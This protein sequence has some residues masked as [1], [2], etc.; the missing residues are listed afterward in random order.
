MPQIARELRRG[1]QSGA[2]RDGY[3]FLRESAGN[4]GFAEW[5]QNGQHKWRERG[6]P[7]AD[8]AFSPASVEAQQT[9]LGF[10]L[11]LLA[12]LLEHQHAQLAK[13]CVEREAGVGVYALPCMGLPPDV[14]SAMEALALTPERVATF[15]EPFYWDLGIRR[16]GSGSASYLHQL[17]QS[18]WL[19]YYPV[20]QG[21]GTQGEQ[22][23]VS[24]EVLTYAVAN[25]DSWKGRMLERIYETAQERA[26]GKNQ[27]KRIAE[28]RLS[29]H[30]EFESIAAQKLRSAGFNAAV[31][32][33]TVAGRALAS[34][35]VDLLAFRSSERGSIL[36]VGEVKDFSLNVRRA[37]GIQEL[38]AKVGAA[39]EQL[40][41]KLTE[42]G[43]RWREVLAGDLTRGA[44]IVEPVSLLGV[45]ITSR[46]LPAIL[47]RRFPLV[48]I[49]DLDDFAADVV[50][51]GTLDMPRFSSTAIVRAAS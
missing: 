36:I 39:D 24:A 28:L 6:F 45:V 17:A 32:I 43:G 25:L 23:W 13:L 8:R 14:A 7:A 47:Q 18:N 16:T 42:L 40:A 50:R 38:A 3:L 31:A 1:G 44:A 35:E 29:A 12:G 5:L 48:G 20:I 19:N 15:A 22:W 49:D 4:L 37:Q 51:T 33:E 11:E 10:S 30:R 21:G 9:L 26:L 27:L 46:D 34:G 2:I 41:R